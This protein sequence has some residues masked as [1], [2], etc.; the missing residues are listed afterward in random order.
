MHSAE[1]VQIGNI[2]NLEPK[3]ISLLPRSE[4]TQLILSWSS[5]HK[6]DTRLIFQRSFLRIEVIGLLLTADFLPL[7]CCWSSLPSCRTFRSSFRRWRFC[8]R[9]LWWFMGFRHSL[10][11]WCTSRWGWCWTSA[12]RCLWRLRSWFSKLRSCSM[13]NRFEYFTHHFVAK[14]WSH[15]RFHFGL[16][17]LRLGLGQLNSISHLADKVLR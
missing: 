17:P 11:L 3:R 7:R 5:V 2:K 12:F 6:D 1:F 16:S 13:S 9:C 10:A 14:G 4:S 8:R 15:L